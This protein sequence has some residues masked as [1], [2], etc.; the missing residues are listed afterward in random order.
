MKNEKKKKTKK[1]RKDTEVSEYGH[2]TKGGGGRDRRH[3][4]REW[5]QVI[6]LGL[7]L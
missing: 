4:V 7:F 1:K 5:G 2:V 3:R 6:R